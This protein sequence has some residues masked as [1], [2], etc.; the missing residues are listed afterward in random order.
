[1]PKRFSE[2]QRMKAAEISDLGRNL[3]NEPAER[4]LRFVFLLDS[5]RHE[6]EW[7][8]TRGSRRADLFFV[9]IL[10]H[11]ILMAMILWRVW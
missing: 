8:N 7:I 3:A 4:Y 6:L 11:I 9:L 10:V 5:I 2:L 1:M